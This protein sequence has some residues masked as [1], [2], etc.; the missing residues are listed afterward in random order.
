MLHYIIAYYNVHTCL[1]MYHVPRDNW[2]TFHCVDIPPFRLYIHS[3]ADGQLGVLSPSYI[4]YSPK[5]SVNSGLNFNLQT[6]VEE[7]QHCG[8][9][10]VSL[11]EVGGTVWLLSDRCSHLS[12]S[13]Y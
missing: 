5:D 3:S 10:G 6:W 9:I 8:G 2:A 4:Y 1:C 12:S 13:E 11:M 7:N